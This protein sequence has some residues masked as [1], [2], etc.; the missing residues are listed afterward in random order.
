[1]HIWLDPLNAGAMTRM[2]ADSL[3]EIDPHNSDRYAANAHELLHRLV[4]LTAEIEADVASARGKP[5]VVFHDGYR[6]FEDRFGLTA[7]GSAVV[8]PERSPGVKRIR[9]L[10]KK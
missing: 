6:Y 2:I 1:M 10:R 5:F 9:E 8:S 7:A 4:D 3:S